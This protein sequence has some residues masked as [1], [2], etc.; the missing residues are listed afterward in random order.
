M[1]IFERRTYETLGHSQA[2]KI[3]HTKLTHDHLMK[4]LLSTLLSGLL[5]ASYRETLIGGVLERPARPTA[6]LEYPV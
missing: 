6:I 3:D 1:V 2:L 5:G 4:G